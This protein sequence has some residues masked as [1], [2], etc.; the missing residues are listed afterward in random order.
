VS[1][2]APP[3]KPTAT[4][5]GQGHRDAA[6][7]ANADQ[8]MAAVNEIATQAPTAIRIDDPDVP[9][10][11]DGSRIGTAPPVTQPGR[12]P[13]SQKAVDLN[14]TILS[15]S[16]LAAVLGGAVSA[17]LWSTG[18]ANPTVVAWVCGCIVGIPAA[19]T[20]PVLAL[21]SLMK[22]AKDVVEAAPPTI[23]NHYSGQITQTTNT[24]NADTKGLVAI[25]RNQLPPAR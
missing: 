15:S 2:P 20:L 16:V 24:I 11:K 12:P 7:R 18:H 8:L 21:K 6:V 19:F 23:H 22:S 17:V 9:S 25:T 14:T 3:Q 5:A 4:T 1:T 10:W 13:M